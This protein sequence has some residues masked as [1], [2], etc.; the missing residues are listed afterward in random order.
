MNLTKRII[1][2][3]TSS[4]VPTT[5][6]WKGMGVQQLVV[7]VVSLATLNWRNCVRK[8]AVEIAY[9]RGTLIRPLRHRRKHNTTRVEIIEH[10]RMAGERSILR[11]NICTSNCSDELIEESQVCETHFA[12]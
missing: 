7:V 6:Y 10:Q 1:G 9:I 4:K 5:H 12:L 8:T 11:D 2:R 3:K